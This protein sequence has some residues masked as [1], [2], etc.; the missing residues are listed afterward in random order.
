MYEKILFEGKYH[1]SGRWSYSNFINLME[2]L[3]GDE[4]DVPKTPLIFESP[5]S[6][7]Q[8]I[9]HGNRTT[10]LS[11]QYFINKGIKISFDARSNN[12]ND[13]LNQSVWKICGPDEG[14]VSAIEKIL[15]ETL[16]SKSHIPD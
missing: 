16:E 8:R 4:T 14:S 3:C 13:G 9:M 7:C 15:F 12:G 1:L 11:S 5:N 2:Y 10:E 6:K